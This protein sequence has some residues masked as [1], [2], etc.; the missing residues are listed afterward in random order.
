MSFNFNFECH[1]SVTMH[2][3]MHVYY[4]MYATKGISAEKYQIH[5]RI[6]AKIKIRNILM[7]KTY[8]LNV[9][10]IY[11]FPIIILFTSLRY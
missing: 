11:F 3:R 8:I 7:Y 2:V 10:R 5:Q 4:K 1:L 9:K 6:D